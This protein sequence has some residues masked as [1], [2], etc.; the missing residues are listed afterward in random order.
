MIVGRFLRR[1]GHLDQSTHASA[2]KPSGSCGAEIDLLTRHVVI[3]HEPV[4]NR[5]SLLQTPPALETPSWFQLKISQRNQHIWKAARERA[6]ER[7]VSLSALL[8]QVL[9][10]WLWLHPPRT[11]EERDDRSPPKRA[12]R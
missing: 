4:M 1:F 9:A 3:S 8:N 5:K 7:G 10:D 11:E 2:D 6:A 12:S